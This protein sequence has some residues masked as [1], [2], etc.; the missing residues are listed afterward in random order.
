MQLFD[1]FGWFCFAVWLKLAEY[2]GL[3]LVFGAIFKTATVTWF[4]FKRL[5][6]ISWSL[7]KCKT[8]KNVS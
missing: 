6:E 2:D 7:Y 3:L 8:S 5:G 4:A 1:L